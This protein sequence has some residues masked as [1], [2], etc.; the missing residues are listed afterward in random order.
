MKKLPLLF[1]F[2]LCFSLNSMAQTITFEY[3]SMGSQINRTYNATGSRVSQEQAK[4]YKDLVTNDFQK[5]FPED[6]ISYYPNPV[7]DELFVK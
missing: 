7:K 4:E 5:F 6:I 1:L 3:D 2:L